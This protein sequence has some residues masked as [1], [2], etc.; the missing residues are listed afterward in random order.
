MTLYTRKVNFY[1]LLF[2]SFTNLSQGFVVCIG[3]E[4]SYFLHYFFN[5]SPVGPSENKGIYNQIY[6]VKINLKAETGNL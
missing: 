3:K 4:M 2:A 6:L 5:N 1:A